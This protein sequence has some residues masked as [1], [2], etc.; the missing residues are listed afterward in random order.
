[1]RFDSDVFFTLIMYPAVAVVF[2]IGYYSR[3]VQR[4]KSLLCAAQNTI[5]G[6]FKPSLFKVLILD[7]RY[8]GRRCVI[9]VNEMYCPV[10]RLRPKSRAPEFRGHMLAVGFADPAYVLSREILANEENLIIV[11]DEL[12]A[13]CE[14]I[15]KGTVVGSRT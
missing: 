2:F 7:G 3:V 5:A 9:S 12:S 4:Y 13:I 1:M 15:E 10:V 8:Q 14:T 6:I 11:L